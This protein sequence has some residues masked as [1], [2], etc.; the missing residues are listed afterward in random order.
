M[1]TICSSVKNAEAAWPNRQNEGSCSA[2]F[3]RWAV[4]FKVKYGGESGIRTH[5]RVS[6]KHAFQACAFSHSAI[7]P[8]KYHS[9]RKLHF[10]FRD[11]WW[12]WQTARTWLL[13]LWFGDK[14]RRG[15]RAAVGRLRNLCLGGVFGHAIVQAEQR[16]FK[17]VSDAQLVINFAQIIL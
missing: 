17:P 10:D 7:S 3:A 14:R 9:G 4:T 13:L 16:E 12:E 11:H 6:P 1:H 5:V 15:K 8:D 2:C